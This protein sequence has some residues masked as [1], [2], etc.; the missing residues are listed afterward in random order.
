VNVLPLAA[1][2]VMRCANRA[3]A[4]T[5]PATVLAAVAAAAAL[6]GGVAF[7]DEDDTPFSL[8]L[9]HSILRDSNFSRTTQAQAETVNST[10]LRLGLDK[11]YGRQVYRAGAKITS[12][13]YAHY[14][15]LLNNQGKDFNGSITSGIASNW[16]VSAN[17]LYSENLNQIQNNQ[18][19]ARLT[20]N[21]RKYRDGGFSVQYGNG[22]TWALVGSYDANRTRYSETASQYQNADQHTTGF[23]AVYNSSDVLNFGLGERQVRTQ[24]PNQSTGL[25]VKDS[26][27]DVSAN[28]Q[29]TGISNLGVVLTR[30]TSKYSNDPDTSVTGWTGSLDWSYTPRG[31]LSYGV[32]LSRT[33]G[34][35]R[36]KFGGFTVETLDNGVITVGGYLAAYNS[37][38]NSLNLS[39]RMQ[40]TGKLSFSA[41]YSLSKYAVD[42]NK[43]YFIGTVDNRSSHSVGHA[44]RLSGNYAATRSINLGCG[45]STY[46]QTRDLYRLRYAGRSVDCNASFTLD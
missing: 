7:A 33:T 31:L 21:I 38:T 37:V 11:A 36:S 39:S 1:R 32:S 23:R 27:F 44:A 8:T 25:V 17:G 42:S 34:S 14:G 19:T 5:L 6:A 35:D 29:A 2:P 40:A 3:V 12:N 4:P 28:W 10:G 9:S 30:R 18:T 46:S 24:Y 20:R 13:R 16:L 45:V 26:N 43:A 22:G 41:A 15:D